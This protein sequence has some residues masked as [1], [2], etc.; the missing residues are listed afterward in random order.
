MPELME[1]GRPLV[2][3]ACPSS[4]VLSDPASGA[5]RQQ[6]IVDQN[7]LNDQSGKKYPTSFFYTLSP[8]TL[9]KY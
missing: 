5:I 2:F 3:V 6:P 9:Q 4:R 7:E 8:V 1:R